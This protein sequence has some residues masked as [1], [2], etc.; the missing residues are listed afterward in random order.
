M[1]LDPNQARKRN[2]AKF[3]LAGMCS[4][5]GDICEETSYTPPLLREERIT[6]GLILQDIKIVLAHWD[7]NYIELKRRENE[8]KTKEKRNNA[9]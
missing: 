6:L 8:R 3:R 1:K 7:E 9:C 5:L 4:F 2:F